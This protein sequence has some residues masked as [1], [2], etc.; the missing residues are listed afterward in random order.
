MK[1]YHPLLVSLHWLLAIMIVTGLIM[2]SVV[3]SKTPNSAPEKIDYLRMHMTMGAIIGLLMLVRLL[4]RVLSALPEHATSGQAVLDKLGTLAH[5][6]FYVLVFS[7]VG[8]G[9]ALSIQADLPQ[10]VFQGM[11][12]SLPSDFWQFMPRKI[13][14]AATKILAALIVLHFVAFLYHQFFL[15]DSL[16]QRMWF[17]SR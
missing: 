13:H 10:I 4:I 2:G 11:P 14:G 16:F 6:T 9:I 17:G 7:V 8:S 12:N 1:R 5:Y 3:L 15:K